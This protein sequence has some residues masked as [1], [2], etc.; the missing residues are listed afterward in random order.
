MIANAPNPAGL[1]ILK[2]SFHEGAVS[3]A[4]LFVGA[5]VPTAVAATAFLL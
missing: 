3:A 4:G 2:G 5:L 1:S